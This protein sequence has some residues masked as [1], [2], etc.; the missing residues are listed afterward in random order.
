MFPDNFCRMEI[1][2]RIRKER[3]ARGMTVRELGKR[4]GT[5][6][7]AVSQWESGGG[8]AV[9]N[10]VS[11]SDALEIPITDLMPKVARIAGQLAELNEQEALLV[12]RFRALD[13]KLREA[14]LR[15]IVAQAPDDGQ[16]DPVNQKR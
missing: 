8:I 11:L 15:M 16:P 3:V 9:Q 6:G 2:D 1:G 5:S 4:I 10:R 13:P 7:A 14:Y 12:D